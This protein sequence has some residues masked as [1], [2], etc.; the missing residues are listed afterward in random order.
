MW[1]PQGN[2]CCMPVTWASGRKR[3]CWARSRACQLNLKDVCNSPGWAWGMGSFCCSVCTL[4][5]AWGG[6]IEDLLMGLPVWGELLKIAHEAL[7]CLLSDSVDSVNLIEVT[8]SWKKQLLPW[9]S[10][11]DELTL[12]AS[13]PLC[14]VFYNFIKW[15][16]LPAQWVI[17][18]RA[19]VPFE[20]LWGITNMPWMNTTFICDYFGL[21]HIIHN[22]RVYNPCHVGQHTGIHMDPLLELFCIF[23]GIPFTKPMIVFHMALFVHPKSLWLVSNAQVM[24]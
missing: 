1:H 18:R 9:H 12:A 19:P 5:L 23:E 4:D 2:A 8:L 22:H 21:S 3:V 6:E 13:N 16:N 17:K 20:R 10:L 11:L 14:F 15:P 7:Q 24:R